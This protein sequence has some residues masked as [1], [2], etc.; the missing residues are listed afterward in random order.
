MIVVGLPS[1]WII[2]SWD[3]Q[4]ISSFLSFLEDSCP[5]LTINRLTMATGP[6]TNLFY[7]NVNK[8]LSTFVPTHGRRASNQL[9]TTI[10]VKSYGT[11]TCRSCW[12]FKKNRSL[13]VSFQVPDNKSTRA[14]FIRIPPDASVL[15]VKEL[16][17]DLWCGV[18]DWSDTSFPLFPIASIVLASISGYFHHR[19]SK[20]VQYETKIATS[21]STWSVES[22]HNHR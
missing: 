10:G 17:K 22:R 9:F 7:D 12:V 8:I 6:G 14:Q 18:S 19:W 21:I 16:L 20:R 5:V 11:I 3:N 15:H 2:E 4:L 1:T 13:L